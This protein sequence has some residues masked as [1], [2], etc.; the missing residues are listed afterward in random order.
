[1]HL[2]QCLDQASA[3]GSL[4]GELAGQSIHDEMAS[5]PAARATRGCLAFEAT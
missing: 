3:V 5:T 2:T 1:M 4:P